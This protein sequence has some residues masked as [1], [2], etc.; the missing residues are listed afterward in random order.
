MRSD[1]KNPPSLNTVSSR[2]LACISVKGSSTETSLKHS[3]RVSEHNTSSCVQVPSGDLLP[4]GQIPQQ[5]ERNRIRVSD[6]ITSSPL[7]FKPP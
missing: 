7:L 6:I 5:P 3:S 2:G 4:G 1:W